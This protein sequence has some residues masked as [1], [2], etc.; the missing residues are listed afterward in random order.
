M[1]PVR[2]SSVARRRTKKKERNDPAEVDSVLAEVLMKLIVGLGNPGS[3]YH[4]TRHNVGFEVVNAFA[5]RHS[6][7]AAKAR[8]DGLVIDGLVGAEKV[9]LL[10][11]QTYM[12]ASGRSVR[13]C[14]DFYRVELSDLIVVLDDMNL[15]AGRLR[16]R[17]SGSAGG[18]KGLAD[19]IRHLGSDA[20][21]RLRLGIGRPPGKMDASDFVL[22]RFSEHERRELDV[23][24]Q[25]AVDGLDLWV[26]SDLEAAMNLVNRPTAVDREKTPKKK[27]QSVPDG[28]PAKG[29]PAKP[30]SGTLPA[31]GD[32]PEV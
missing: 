11:P 2:K 26:K 14:V 5:D 8:F 3:R 16:L 28:S 24:V 7:A 23:S 10:A 27:S 6:F 13:S 32:P 1:L 29:K 20:F 18:Q 22:Q 19:I 25:E 4:L 17:P 12:N 31:D 9:V 15:D 30:S 21:P